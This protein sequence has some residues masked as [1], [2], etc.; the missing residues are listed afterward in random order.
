MRAQRG[1]TLTAVM[2]AIIAITGLLMLGLSARTN[3]LR[4]EGWSQCRAQAKW[5]AESAIASGRA[6][7]S[8]GRVGPLQGKLQKGRYS[9]TMERLGPRRVAM[10]AVGSCTEKDHTARIKIEAQ[11]QQKTKRWL[12]KSWRQGPASP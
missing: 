10:V 9:L 12:V 2:L 7:L 4:H 6:R 1:A 11:L 8:S 5:A 3:D